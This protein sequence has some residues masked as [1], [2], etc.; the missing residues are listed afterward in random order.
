[1]T[2]VVYCKC[3]FKDPD[4]TDVPGEPCPIHPLSPFERAELTAI[5]DE[6]DRARAKG[7]HME[8]GDCWCLPRL[9]YV[10]DNGNQVWV[11]HEPN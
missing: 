10:A 2:T 8:A 3:T 4:G 9:D 5:E 11:H 1:M 6:Q 7:E